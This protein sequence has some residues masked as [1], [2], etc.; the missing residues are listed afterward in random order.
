M[1][2]V[3]QP[4]TPKGLC[5]LN[6]GF[7]YDQMQILVLK[8]HVPKLDCNMEAHVHN[9]RSQRR[10]VI[11]SNDHSNIQAISHIVW[12][13]KKHEHSNIQAISHIVWFFKKHEH[14]SIQAISHIVWFFKKHEHSNIQAISHIVWFFKKHSSYLL[15]KSHIPKQTE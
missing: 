9:L 2:L 7:Q 6:K 13:F 15:S 14:S 10:F 3:I 4:Y 12:F 11:R 5:V 8:L 1:N